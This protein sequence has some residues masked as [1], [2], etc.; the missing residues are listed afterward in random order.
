MKKIED[1]NRKYEV[2][3][4]Y[5]IKKSFIVDAKSDRDLIDKIN[6]DR[7]ATHD[8]ETELTDFKFV[9][10]TAWNCELGSWKQINVKK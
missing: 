6:S 8:E 2:E 9:K 7:F 5:T 10:I 4:K 3:F 1:M